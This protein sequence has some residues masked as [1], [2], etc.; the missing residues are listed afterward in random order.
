LSGRAIRWLT[1]LL[2]LAM[3]LP[4]AAVLAWSYWDVRRDVR[5]EM[6]HVSTAALNRLDAIIGSGAEQL[7]VLGNLT[8]TLAGGCDNEVQAQLR[9][10]VFRSPYFREAG[11]L[12]DD[13]QLCNQY[14]RFEPPVD[15][16]SRLKDAVVVDGLLISA[17]RIPKG[18]PHSLILAMRYYNRGTGYLIVHP[19]AMV[20]YLAFF[21]PDAR[22]GVY[23][24]YDGKVALSTVGVIED[25]MA[26]Q[27]LASVSGRGESEHQQIFAVARS[28]KYPL[29][30]AAVSNSHLALKRWAQRLPFVGLLALLMAGAGYWLTRR[31]ASQALSMHAELARAIASERL[32]VEYQPFFDV[33]TGIVGGVEALVRWTR[34]PEGPL[35]PAVFVPLAEQAGLLPAMTQ[36]VF[37]RVLAELAPL[38]ARYPR[39]RVSINCHVSA[40]T[41]PAFAV[42][43]QQWQAAGLAADRLVFE[44]TER[45]DAHFDLNSVKAPMQALKARGVSFAMDDFGVGF[46]NLNSLRNLPFDFLKIDKAFV[47]GIT[48]NTDSS[49]FVDHIMELANRMD[50]R[51]VA[52]GV[53]TEAQRDYLLR[54]GVRYMQGWLFSRSMSVD[55]LA[56]YLREYRKATGQESASLQSAGAQ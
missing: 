17:Q 11:V 19:A 2:V 5:R 41:D 24:L 6:T 35:S 43:T 46:S 7:Q 37:K 26:Q 31:L 4:V 38:L 50:L 30:I 22:H 23:Y 27:L 45:A 36:L 52:E 15:V 54:L 33:Q 34:R 13:K 21:E 55:R 29:A 18:G 10:I 1:V 32:D 42:F 53:E 40:L 39:M 28:A 56:T 8:D 14:E 49:G 20:D 25:E 51:V 47:D 48:S 44:V 3:V 16:G 9:D 12:F